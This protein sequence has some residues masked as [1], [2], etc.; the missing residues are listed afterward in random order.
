[1]RGHSVKFKIL[2]KNNCSEQTEKFVGGKP[3]LVIARN[4]SNYVK[5]Q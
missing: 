2:Q 4:V 5:R 3:A 1:M